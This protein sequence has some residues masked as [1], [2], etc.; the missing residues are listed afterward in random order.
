MLDPKI[1][2]PLA[3]SIRENMLTESSQLSNIKNDDETILE[4]RGSMK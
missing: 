4:I 1:A 3:E 2:K